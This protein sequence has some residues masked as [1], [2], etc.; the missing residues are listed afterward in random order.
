MGSVEKGFDL[1]KEDPELAY[2]PEIHHEPDSV[3][4][5]DQKTPNVRLYPELINHVPLITMQ[6]IDARIIK[7]L[8][9]I[10]L[11][12]ATSTNA[13]ES[14]RQEGITFTILSP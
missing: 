3:V 12:V 10:G 5:G 11:T 4:F 2:P 1:I 9:G 14:M 6:E 13:I 7:A 8:T